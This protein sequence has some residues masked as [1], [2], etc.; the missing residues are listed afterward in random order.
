MAEG[1]KEQK[2]LS[3]Q[4]LANTKQQGKETTRLNDLNA[5]LEQLYK[6]HHGNLKI[7]GQFVRDIRKD[8]EASTVA[9]EKSIAAKKKENKILQDNAFEINT[10]LDLA[11]KLGDKI[12]DGVESIPLVGDMLSEKLNLD[13]LGENIQKQVFD[14]LLSGIRDGGE[15]GF[16]GFFKSF[17]GIKNIIGRNIIGPISKMGT[18]GKAAA[19]VLRRAM[20]I[21]LGP[22]GLIVAGFTAA[23]MIFKNIRKAQREFGEAVGI[24]RDQVGLLAV[25]TKV[26]EKS[27]NAIGLDGSKIKTTLGEIGKEFGS[28]E[29]MTVANAASIERFAQNAGVA[30]SEVVKLNKLFMDLEGLSFDAATNV[31]RVAADLAKEANVSTARVIGDMASSAEKF[32]E[33]STMGADGFA[34]A[35]VEAAKVGT[36]LSGILGAADKLLNFESSISAQFEAQVLTGKQI[37]LEK[38]RQLSLDG[39]IAGLTTEIQ[40]IVGQVGDIQSLN[41]IQRGKIA[42]AIGI[43]VG[44]L[45]KISRGEEVAQ[46]ETVLDEQKKTNELLIEGLDIDREA[47]DVAK[48]KNVSIQPGLF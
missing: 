37:N 10:T 35:A 8:T 28:L 23:F 24:S 44:D 34:K 6:G 15:E 40:S 11:D 48:D 7:G 19:A 25:K 18:T 5:R 47:L 32:A 1:I 21:A 9:L 16:Q 4:I 2:L 42:E 17:D 41:V 38:A 27:F 31:S 3:D 29:N 20:T 30:G 12:K 45:I 46:G 36:S 39:D 33:F 14:N 26:V 43:S 22:V 13:D